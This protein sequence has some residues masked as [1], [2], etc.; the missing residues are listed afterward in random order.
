MAHYVDAFGFG[1][2]R[3][4]ESECKK[5]CIVKKVFIEKHPKDTK[6]SKRKEQA[7]DI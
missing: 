4:K 6:V 2:C 7:N 3:C 5:D 1:E